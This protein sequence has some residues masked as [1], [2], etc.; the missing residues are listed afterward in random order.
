MVTANS[1]VLQRCLG[2]LALMVSL[3][4]SMGLQAPPSTAQSR[5]SAATIPATPT[6]TP[7]QARLSEQMAQEQAQFERAKRLVAG[8]ADV[9]AR[10][11]AALQQTC[12]LARQTVTWQALG[13]NQISKRELCAMLAEADSQPFDPLATGGWTIEA[14]AVAANAQQWWA[15]AGNNGLWRGSN[16][17]WQNVLPGFVSAVLESSTPESPRQSSVYVLRQGWEWLKSTDQGQSF[18][19]ASLAPLQQQSDDSLP[20]PPL[21]VATTVEDLWTGGR[22]LWRS[23]DGGTQ[24]QRASRALPSATAAR[25]SAIAVAPGQPDLVVAGTDHGELFRLDFAR[26]ANDQTNWP[27][28]QPRAGFITSLTFDPQDSNV[29]YATYGTFGGAHIWKS[30]NGGATWFAIDGEGTAALPDVPV[31][32]LAVEPDDGQR[33]YAGTDLGVFTTFDGGAHWQLLAADFGAASVRALALRQTEAGK[34]LFVFTAAQGVWAA[35]LPA[36][37]PDGSGLQQCLVSITPTGS[38]FESGG[39]NGSI[40]IDTIPTCQWMAESNS[41][42]VQINAPTAGTGAGR[43]TF[44]VAPNPV[45]TGRNATLTVGRRTFLIAQQGVEEACAT[46]PVRIGITLGGDLSPSDCLSAAYPGQLHYA[47]RYSFTGRKGEFVVISVTKS[48]AQVGSLALLTPEGEVYYD[49]N[50]PQQEVRW[51]GYLGGLRELPATGTYFF[52]VT[53]REPQQS[54]SYQVTLQQMPVGCGR[55]DVMPLDRYFDPARTTGRVAISTLP[56]CRWDALSNVPWISFA[57]PNGSGNALLEFAIASNTGSSIRSGQLEIA[58]Q[59]FT[60]TQAGAVGNCVPLPL[61]VGGTVNGALTASDCPRRVNDRYASNQPPADHYQFTGRAGQ[62]V[63]LALNGASQALSYPNIM[64]MTARGDVLANG[65]GR[66]PN[67]TGFVELPNDGSYLVA[68]T[69]ALDT[70]PVPYALS[71]LER[72]EACSYALSPLQREFE[73]GGGAVEFQLNTS[74]GCAWT[75]LP[76]PAWISVEAAS[77]QGA[78]T[79]RLTTA[80]NLENAARRTLVTI[81]GQRAVVTQAGAQSS[82]AAQAITPG[83]LVAAQFSPSDCPPQLTYDVNPLDPT[84][85]N[86]PNSPVADRYTFQASQAGGAQQFS[87]VLNGLNGFNGTAAWYALADAQGRVLA[88]GSLVSGQLTLPVG[89]PGAGTYR[90]ELGPTSTAAYTYSFQVNLLPTGC[91]TAGQLSQNRFEAAGG[92]GT[93]A[94]TAGNGCLWQVTVNAGV[95]P[96]L[97]LNGNRNGSGATALGFSVARNTSGSARAA[98]L[99]LGTETFRIEQAGTSGVCA[100]S[101]ITPGQVV[102]GNLSSGDCSAL[103][104][105]ILQRTAT[106]PT[107]RYTFT[108]MAGQQLSLT[109]IGLSGPDISGNKL[110]PVPTLVDPLGQVLS[111]SHTN[112]LPDGSYL[113]PLTGRYTV[114]V[115]AAQDPPGLAALGGPYHLLAELTT[116]GCSYFVDPSPLRF[117]NAAATHTLQVTTSAGCA[118]TPRTTADWLTVNPATNA[119]NGT[120]T[121][122]L[123]R[124]ETS[125]ARRAAVLVGGQSV[126]VEQAGIGGDCRV[127]PLTAGMPVT[128]TLNA[129]DCAARS[130][131]NSVADRYSFT[132]QAG[133][134]VFFKVNFLNNG[135]PSG[136]PPPLY[137]YDAQG[138]SLTG[139]AT[140][141]IAP[142]TYLRLAVAGTYFLEVAYP[143]ATFPYTLEMR[144]LAGTCALAVA[145]PSQLFAGAAS[146]GTLTVRAAPG[147]QWTARSNVP[148]LTITDGAQGA[149]NGTINFAVAELSTSGYRDGAIYVEDRSVSIRQ[150]FSPPMPA[151]NPRPIAFG[152]TINAALTTSDCVSP[153]SRGGRTVYVDTYTFEANAEHRIAFEAPQRQIELQLTVFELNPNG[154]LLGQSVSR[155]PHAPNEFI[156][157]PHAGRYYCEVISVSNSTTGNYTLKLATPTGCDALVTFANPTAGGPFDNQ[158]FSVTGGTG[159]VK[160]ETNAECSWTAQSSADWLQTTGSGMGPGTFSFTVQP[161]P[162]ANHRAARLF[163]N[164]GGGAVGLLVEQLGTGGNCTVRVLTPGEYVTGALTTGDCRLGLTWQLAGPGQIVDRFQFAAQAGDQIIVA[165]D[166]T[167]LPGGGYLQRGGF[168]LYDPDGQILGAGNQVHI[169][170]ANY[171]PTLPAGMLTLPK[172]GVYTLHYSAA[173]PLEYAFRFGLTAGG[174]GFVLPSEQPQFTSAGGTGSLTLQ[175]TGTCAWTALSLTDWLTVNTPNGAGSGTVTFTVAPNP[176]DYRFGGLSIAGRMVT[177]FQTG[178]GGSCV[179]V[180]LTLGQ[181]LSNELNAR[182]CRRTNPDA[183]TSVVDRYSF[184]ARAGERVFVKAAS[185]QVIAAAV[186]SQATLN[187]G[188]LVPASDWLG[189]ASYEIPADG[190][191]IIEVFSSY[192]TQLPAPY[193][194]RVQVLPPGCGVAVNLALAEFSSAGG[195]GSVSITAGCEYQILSSHDW[196]T[197]NGPATRSGGQTLSFNVAPNPN[198][199]ARTGT[200]GIGGQPFTVEQA[201]TGGQC[202]VQTIAPGLT[203]IGQLNRADCPAR[204][205]LQAN[206]RDYADRYVFNATAGQLAQVLGPEVLLDSQFL[207]PQIK[208][209]DPQGG[210]VV[211]NAY[212]GLRL[213]SIEGFVRLPLTGA[214]TLEV[215]SRLP[216]Y[217]NAPPLSLNYTLLLTLLPPAC[218]FTVTPGDMS[219]AAAG[220]SGTVT[221]ATAAACAWQAVADA[222]WVSLAANQTTGSGQVTL[223]VAANPNETLR[224]ATLNI[225]GQSFTL[226][227]AGRN[228]VCAVQP[229]AA[230]Q[231]VTGKFDANDCRPPRTHDASDNQSRRRYSFQG[232]AGEQVDLALELS[233][234]SLST[235][236]LVAPSGVLLLSTFE[237]RLPKLNEWYVLP[238]SG[239]Y[240][241]ELYGYRDVGYALSLFSAPGSCGYALGASGQRFTAAGGAGTVT[242]SA[243]SGCVWQAR[244]DAAWLSVQNGG[245]GNGAFAY[246]VAAN[247]TPQARSGKLTLANRVFIVEQ[248]GPNGSCEPRALQPGR[249]VNGAWDEGDCRNRTHNAPT[250]YFVDRYS[251]NAVA[252]ESLSV[253]LNTQAAVVLIELYDATGSLLTTV[254]GK[255]FPANVGLFVLPASGAYTLHLLSSWNT[256]YTLTS[257]LNPPGAANNGSTIHLNA[258]NF[259]ADALAPDSLVTMFG[260]NLS[261]VTQTANAPATSL[262]G[263]TVQVRDSAGAIQSAQLLFVSPTQINYIM[264]DG[265]AYGAATITTINSNGVELSETV[266]IAPVAPG[267]FA[268]DASGRGLAAGVVMRVKADQSQVFEPLARFDAAQNRFVAVPIDLG[269]ANEAVYLI[270]FGTGYRWRSEIAAVSAQLSALTT[271]TAPVPLQVSYAGQQGNLGGLDQLN[272]ALP[273]ALRGRGECEIRLSVDGKAANALRMVVK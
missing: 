78:A 94:I 170:G 248:A 81:G 126:V 13:P 25:F 272:L 46:V 131:Y 100:A 42:W 175:T 98:T 253:T 67:E 145:E 58:G 75:V 246:T 71:L 144:R 219:F 266:Q 116:P 242:V 64:L 139:L 148:W 56:G 21:A 1:R 191:Y 73:A 79:I 154:H 214:Y 34:R 226:E 185:D 172:S 245:N 243:G 201:G 96:W 69:A 222:P 101:A 224:R 216:T 264:P 209:Y 249:T 15:G 118:W 207:D 147:C 50:A 107:D 150:Q 54:F 90:L 181:V 30:G 130:G 138:N 211:G 23:T 121:L 115:A 159:T 91:A 202:A 83:Q 114:E 177:V 167:P 129:G 133:D 49:S 157:L 182:D 22:Y 106:A 256:A 225:A 195:T 229:I 142:E 111:N 28:V 119:G 88:N 174:C 104:P 215:A 188:Q 77:G 2:F 53:S 4:L 268:A 19:L 143:P 239:V 105:N 168:A 164:Q 37:T 85:C 63:Y 11:R 156:T 93:L 251:F 237:R 26:Q 267:L 162:T 35:G 47:D 127:V 124:N 7:A 234:G 238:V 187:A 3:W 220:G 206:T 48:A 123:A 163:I 183:S 31:N 137:L 51:P 140:R 70:K 223:T 271:N 24:W 263:T 258:A 158:L 252:G 59:R 68:V 76:A 198:A 153:L 255:R 113:L 60:V 141:A 29:V 87:L 132:A 265:L 61:A 92:D 62:R 189:N 179:P 247:N 103:Y 44:T 235:L 122:T 89:L 110:T 57:N 204:V 241:I 217:L 221:V 117:S 166:V 233:F 136:Y 84:E 55:Y 199:Q 210:L 261:E 146:T 74:A 240:T 5:L 236:R 213:P 95:V 169:P 194:L 17:G 135:A 273:S 20:V 171:V 203:V 109:A 184:A 269:A 161:N 108:A 192:N 176:G 33:L 82:C 180:P 86:C 8:E 250:A 254:Y 72:N 66:L 197:F 80:P 38:L 165:Q 196:L 65:G 6:I 18:K 259:K 262:G 232:A 227:Q 16:A 173:Q 97:T 228:G 218:S 231:T 40:A 149:G 99:Q 41:P 193:T 45:R 112:R 152:Q 102:S 39:G 270:L 9:S 134:Q 36:A 32:A 178:A 125:Q 186:L 27:G 190:T 10:Y 260:N 120:L 205:P 212:R 151:C 230:G 160:V 128:G 155:V 244:S 208:L 12:V 43:I 52:E 257:V 200:I 14:G